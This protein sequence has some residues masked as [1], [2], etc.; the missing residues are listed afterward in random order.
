MNMKYIAIY[1]LMGIVCGIAY[2]AYYSRKSGKEAAERND[3]IVQNGIKKDVFYSYTDFFKT[4]CAEYIIDKDKKTLYVS[5]SRGDYKAIPL[6]NI[7]GC[8]VIINGQNCASIGRAVVGG[9]IAGG[10][11]AVVG[12]MTTK[13]KVYSYK[14]VIYVNDINEPEYVFNLVNKKTAAND[15]DYIVANE[16]AQ[17]VTASIKAVVNLY[18]GAGR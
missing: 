14:L 2:Y 5:N 3:Y 11:G 13:K 16:F 6:C 1:F 4:V 18:G 17:K 9:L 10:A 8:N 7:I 15:A 12:A